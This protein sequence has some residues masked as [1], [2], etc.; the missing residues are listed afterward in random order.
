MDYSLSRHALVRRAIKES[1]WL[2]QRRAVGLR[3]YRCGGNGML[4]VLLAGGLEMVPV[5]RVWLG[6]R[7][8]LSWNAIFWAQSALGPA[9]WEFRGR[10]GFQMT[11]VK[12]FRIADLDLTPTEDGPT[13]P[14]VNAGYSHELGAG[15]GV[16]EN[17]AVPWTVTYDEVLFIKEGGL[18]LRAGVSCR[19]GRHPLDPQG[20]GVDL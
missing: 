20:Y 13:V 4:V 19:A 10:T 18:T 5:S 8:P 9:L 3:C 6:R 1:P 15:I 2:L 11:E 12:H 14:V 16:F 7:N 17:C